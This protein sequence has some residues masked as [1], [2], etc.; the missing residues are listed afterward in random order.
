MSCLSPGLAA[1]SGGR[2][3]P[4]LS[5]GGGGPPCLLAHRGWGL[6]YIASYR[7]T[8]GS[9]FH[10]FIKF[11][12]VNVVEE[13]A[14]TSAGLR[15]VLHCLQQSPPP[16]LGLW[17]HLRPTSIAIKPDRGRSFTAASTLTTGLSGGGSNVLFI[18]SWIPKG[19]ATALATAPSWSLA[20][21]VHAPG[22]GCLFPYLISAA[23]PTAGRGSAHRIVHNIRSG[24]QLHNWLALAVAIVYTHA[25]IQKACLCQT[26]GSSSW[27]RCSHLSTLCAWNWGHQ[28]Q[29]MAM[30]QWG[31]RWESW[32]SDGRDKRPLCAAGQ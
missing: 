12:A 11:T 5:V 31:L 9:W 15:S 20:R 13:L 17:H 28:L 26:I 2:A 30:P 6:K 8:R 29:F 27:A 25:Y 19:Q 21:L 16:I 18:L 32:H 22:G 1:V 3:S 7:H 14:T 4:L 10:F 23:E 24:G